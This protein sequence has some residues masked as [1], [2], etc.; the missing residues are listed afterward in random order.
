MA[1]IIYLSDNEEKALRLLAEAKTG[2]QIKAQ[3]DI[4]LAGMGVF[5]SEIRRKTGIRDTRFALECRRYI[6]RY[7]ATIGQ[8]VSLDQIR[9]LRDILKGETFEG[10]AYRMQLEKSV[11]WKLYDQACE[12]AA[13]FTRDEKARRVQMRLYL[14]TFHTLPLE[15]S[16]AL[17]SKETLFLKM[18]A[19]G[20]PYAQIADETKERPEFVQWKIKGICSRLGLTA[21]GRDTQRRLARAFL[22]YGAQTPAPALPVTMDDPAFN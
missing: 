2:P 8:P 3:C 16:N 21:R 9:I 18:F 4:P 12:S 6:E 14:A 13:I 7:E 1:K 22:A 5:T 11:V 15:G 20:L 10:I 19:D 17:S